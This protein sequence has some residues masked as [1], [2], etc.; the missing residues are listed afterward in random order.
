L[1]EEPILAG[2]EGEVVE[3]G[4]PLDDF[5]ET[6]GLLDVSVRIEP[7]ICLGHRLATRMRTFMAVGIEMP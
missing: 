4:S 3:F 5:D 7:S 1:S 2:L 6:T